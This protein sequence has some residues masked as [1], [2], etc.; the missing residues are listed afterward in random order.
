VSDLQIRL[1]ARVRDFRVRRGLTQEG[2]G[3]RAGLS[4]KFIGQVERGTGNPTV[5]SID[6]IARA[7]GVDVSDLFK[8]EAGDVA[9]TPLSPDDFAIVREAKTSL[10]SVLKRLGS[11]SRLRAR[12]RRK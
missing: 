5:D 12:K 4:Y 9:Y 11:E 8:R 6:Q 7:L 2:L 3:E 1:G 10:E